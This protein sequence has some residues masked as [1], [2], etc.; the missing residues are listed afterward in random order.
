L[1]ALAETPVYK[2]MGTNAAGFIIPGED[3]PI[4]K[5]LPLARIISSDTKVTQFSKDDVEAMGYVKIDLLGLRALQTLNGTLTLIGKQ[6]NEWDWI[7]DDD[8]KAC[9][10]L[11][12]GH[13]TGTFQY[14]GFSSKKGAQEMG[15]KST[16]D[17]ILGLAL[18]RP[19]LMNGGQKDLYLANRGKAKVKQVRLH[20]LFDPVVQDTAGVPLYQE[21]IMEMLQAL[22]MGFEDWNDLMTAVKASN[23]FIQGAAET[24]KRLMPVFYDLCEDAGFSD[25]DADTAWGA[26]IGF[27]E[28]GFNRAHSS[29]Y[30]LMSYWSAYLKAHYPLEYMA[31]L[32]AVWTGD[33]DHEPEYVSE[34]RRMG[35]S[36]VKADVNYSG[37]EW[38]IEASRTNALRRGLASIKGIGWAVADVI[39]AERDAG[40]PYTSIQ[41]FIDR[42]PNRPV[43]GGAKWKSKQELVG[44]CKVLYTAGAFRSL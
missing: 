41:D 24:F 33:K 14:D 17:C 16:L 8:P 19:A 26:V 31:S 23:G 36:T 10:L 43:T 7:P 27:T 4:D 2:S 20:P 5:Y 9:M 29:A 35:M 22:G 3:Y 6:P 18:Y 37:V 42:T 40:G 15:I 44:V 32:L 30:G 12:R 28:Y 34:A 38:Q 11:R 13:S 25:H 39:V 21:Q 1:N